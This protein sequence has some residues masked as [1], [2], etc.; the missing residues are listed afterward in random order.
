MDV[1]GG[2]CCL[3]LRR[4]SLLSTA[5]SRSAKPCSLV[6]WLVLRPPLIC[7]VPAPFPGLAERHFAEQAARVAERCP[8][9]PPVTVHRQVCCDEWCG[10]G[11]PPPRTSA[12]GAATE[13]PT[14]TIVRRPARPSLRAHLREPVARRRRTR[15]AAED[16]AGAVA[17]VLIVVGL[18]TVYKAAKVRLRTLTLSD[19]PQTL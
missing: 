13:A 5:R 19:V 9:R 4:S 14:A 16:F 3:R 6:R 15:R 17:V 18:Y 10:Q 11:L 7:S 1:R 8:A 2:S 12:G